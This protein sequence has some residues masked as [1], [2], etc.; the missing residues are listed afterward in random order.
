MLCFI[1]FYV[2]ISY[3]FM[4]HYYLLLVC[5][6]FKWLR[7]WCLNPMINNKTHNETEKSI[8]SQGTDLLL[9]YYCLLNN[10]NRRSKYLVLEPGAQKKLFGFCMHWLTM[11]TVRFN[12]CLAQRLAP[13]CNQ[14]TNYLRKRLQ[15]TITFM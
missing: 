11:Y 9:A 7:C 1:V 12:I 4:S 15:A 5:H 8:S 13:F 3:F 10:K 2:F 6:L 14:Q